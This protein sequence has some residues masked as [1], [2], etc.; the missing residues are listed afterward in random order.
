MK[1]PNPYEILGIAENSDI[2]TIR[3]AYRKL[4]M[5]WHPDRNAAADAVQ[6]FQI[7]KAAY[8]ELLE[9]LENI[10]D[11]ENN[12]AENDNKNN[13]KNNKKDNKK[14]DIH[15]DVYITLLEGFSGCQKLVEFQRV[16]ICK[17]CNG[18]GDYEN[19]QTN[20]CQHCH[21]TGRSSGGFGKPLQKCNFCNGKGFTSRKIC[22]DCQGQGNISQ[23]ITL[24]VQIP[25]GILQG[26][27]LRLHHQ[28]EQPNQ[29]ESQ[30][31]IEAGD[32][33]LNIH[34][35][36]DKNFVLVE[37]A[38]LY[39]KQALT[40]NLL[41]FFAETKI[42]IPQINGEFLQHKLNAEDYENGKIILKNCGYVGFGKNS[43]NGDLIVPL[44]IKIPKNLSTKHKKNLQK[45]LEEIKE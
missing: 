21:G 22:Q 5:F 3:K 43:K 19:S 20:F 17:T 23:T 18:N 41:D 10:N 8:E 35:D 32:L 27:E 30:K 26:G 14:N 36:E 1:N 33:Y 37:N 34:F 16:Q 39:L 45:I 44:D 7:I 15:L 40:I 6:K 38:N 4:A 29:E 2:N 11:Y 25:K 9:Q 13:K 28:G 12:F 31:G 42:E 24:N